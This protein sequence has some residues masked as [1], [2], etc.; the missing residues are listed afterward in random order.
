MEHATHF[1]FCNVGLFLELN[2]HYVPQLLF[3]ARNIS[4]LL[5]R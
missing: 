3:F 1:F 5:S 2:H 4:K